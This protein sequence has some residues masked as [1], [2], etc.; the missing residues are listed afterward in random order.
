LP[1]FGVL[2]SL[3]SGGEANCVP[4]SANILVE[5]GSRQRRAR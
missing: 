3:C 1:E 2:R 5:D 4:L